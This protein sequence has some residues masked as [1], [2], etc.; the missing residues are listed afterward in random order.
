MMKTKH[1]ILFIIVII[2]SA[3]CSY[4]KK[5]EYE[6]KK[7][8]LSLTQSTSFDVDKAQ[9]GGKITEASV[10]GEITNI[11]KKTMRDVVLTYKFPRA[12]VTAKIKLK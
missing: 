6:V 9:M 7:E 8:S 12:K 10:H 11:S 2:F 3:S 4:F 1:L 5:T